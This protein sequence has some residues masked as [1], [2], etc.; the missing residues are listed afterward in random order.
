MS[1]EKVENGGWELEAV[2][3]SDVSIPEEIRVRGFKVLK[4]ETKEIV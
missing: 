1:G 4:K 3:S 2:D